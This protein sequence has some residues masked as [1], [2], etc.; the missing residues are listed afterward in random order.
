[1]DGSFGIMFKYVIV[2]LRS[3]YKYKDIAFKL[4]PPMA[5][6]QEAHTSVSIHL[7]GAYANQPPR[8]PCWC[9]WCTL[10]DEAAISLEAA[11]P[12]SFGVTIVE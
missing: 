10:E 11:T 9:R 7:V 8:S 3:S 1:M 6:Q 4:R 2:L 12:V 5:Q